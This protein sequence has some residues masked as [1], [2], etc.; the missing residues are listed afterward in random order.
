MQKEKVR[1]DAQA[2]KN[3]NAIILE[4]PLAYLTD[5]P[6]DHRIVNT[7]GESWVRKAANKVETIPD[8]PFWV[9]RPLS[10][11][12]DSLCTRRLFRGCS[13]LTRLWAR[14]LAV[15][16][17]TGSSREGLDLAD[18]DRRGRA[19]LLAAADQAPVRGAHRA[20]RNRS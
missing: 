3:I 15:R 4:I 6:N 14:P 20:A 8:E 2:G 10:L 18:A 19:D 5:T 11:P 16:T 9:E 13:R 17:P 1:I 12:S 7:W